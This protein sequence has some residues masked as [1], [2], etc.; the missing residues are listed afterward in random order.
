MSL[1]IAEPGAVDPALFEQLMRTAQACLELEGVPVPCFAALT[2]TDNADIQA[3]NK[4]RRGIDRATDVLSFPAV[5]YANGQTARDARQ[6]LLRGWDADEHAAFLGDI[7]ISTEKACEQAHAYGHPY[8][9][10]VCYLLAHGMLHVMGYDHVKKEDQET[11][12]KMEEAALSGAQVATSVPDGELLALA[13]QAM[14]RSYSPY[15]HFKVGACLLSQDG[16]TYV[17]SNIENA[18]YG[19]TNCAERT[20]VFTAV[21]DGAREFAA[22]AIAAE[23]AA[24]WP[25]G[26]CRQVLSEFCA[27][28]RVL[29]TW[30]DGE[31]AESTL[32]QLLPHSFSPASGVAN[33]LGKE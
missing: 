5:A 26:V 32:A 10:E 3:I 21:H 27:D 17:G 23:K 33:L 7:V 14:Q 1:V 29:V 25:C 20:A 4:E 2:L 19:A 28:L 9:R 15:S 22:I 12:R 16:R 31:A 24:P 13:R 18:A 8:A 30:G 6:K 11:M